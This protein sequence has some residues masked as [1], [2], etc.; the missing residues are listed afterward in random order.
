[1]GDRLLIVPL[2]FLLLFLDGFQVFIKV[3][4]HVLLVVNVQVAH[5]LV[6]SFA[7]NLLG[8]PINDADDK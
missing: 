4:V 1:M 2:D 6:L 8:D 3:L 5:V 7:V